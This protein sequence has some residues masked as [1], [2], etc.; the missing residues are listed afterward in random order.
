MRG[1]NEVLRQLNA[2]LKCQLTVINQCFLHAR[3]LRHRGFNELN[4][5]EYRHSITAM[6]LADAVIERI[7]FLEG[8]PNLQDLGK[9]L[10]GEDAP[11]ILRQDLALQTATRSALLDAV[12]TCEQV[13]DYVSRDLL[14]SQLE[15]VEEHI[16]W[17][18]TQHQRLKEI[19]LNNYLQSMM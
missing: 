8:L 15:K 4:E 17:L 6:K 2:V 11:E 7:L 5:H 9:L 12:S 19:G 13:Q 10:I 18:E 16:D 3:I 14:E 1:N